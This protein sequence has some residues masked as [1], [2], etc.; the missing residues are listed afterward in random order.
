MMRFAAGLLALLTVVAGVCLADEN[1]PLLL[2][3]PTISATQIVFVYAGDLWSVPRAGGV[4]TRLT[5]GV[6]TASLPVFSPDGSEIAF[7]GEYDGNADVYVIPAGGGT[8][9]RLTYHPAPDDVIGW[10]RDGKSVL[11]ASQRNSYSFFNR[12]YTVSR[13][14]GFPTELPLPG[15]SEGSYSP[16]GKEIAY[17]PLDHAFEIWKRYRGGRSSKVWI[18]KLA[19]SSVTAIPRENTNDFNPM[20]VDERVFF[21]SDRAGAMSLFS[22]DTKTKSVAVALKND[23]LDFKYASAGPGAIAIEQFGAIWLYDLKSGAAHKVDIRISG[24]LPQLRTRYENVG[25]RIR[26]A[27]ISPTGLRAV[28]EARGEILTV[29]AEKGDIRNLTNTPGADERY[30]AWSPDGKSIAYFSD[31]SGEEQLYVKNQNGQGDSQKIDLGTPGSF[32]FFPTWSPDSKRIAYTDKR[33]NLWYVDLE[34]K[35][36]VKVFHDRFTGPEQIFK[37]A[38]SPDSKWLAY[39]GQEVSHMRSVWLYSLETGKSERVTDAM[40][41]SVSPV[42][43]KSGKYLYF[44]SSTDAGPTKDTSM[45]S[46]DRPVTSNVY[47]VVLRKDLPSPLAPLS[48]E[49]GEG[50]ADAAKAD[51]AKADGGKEKEKEKPPVVVK[52]DFEKIGQR[53]LAMPIPARNY[54]EL[55]AGKDGVLFLV[56][57]PL[58][59]P[60]NGADTLSAHRFELKTRRTD[61]LVENI[62]AFY[63]SADGEKL[64]Y[65]HAG[66]PQ[67]GGGAAAQAWSIAPLPPAPV[68]GAPG[69]GAASGGGGNPPGAKNLNFA[70]MEVRIEPIVEWKELYHEAFRLE[71]D[72]FYDANFHGLDLAGTEKKF[73]AYLQGVGSRDD[74]NY[75]FKETM[76]DLTVGHLFVRGGE[77]PEVKRIPVG[78]LGAD[79]KVENGRYRFARVYDGENWNPQLHAPLTQPGVN[80]VEGEYL[81]AVNGREVRGSDEVYSF[82]EETAGKSTLLR[83]GPNADGSGSREVSVVPVESEMGL[84]ELAWVEGNRR[85]VEELS[86]GRLAYIYLPDTASGGYT[87]FNRYFFSQAGKDGAVVDE[88]FNGGGT[89]TDYILDYLRRTLMNYR[90]TRDG[91]DMT[92]PVSLIRGPKAM[93]INEYAG[94]GGDA[95][96]WH[97]RQAKVGTLV[98]K[99]TWGG[100]VGFFGPGESLMDG[101]TVT[102]PSRGFWTPNNDWEVENHGIAPDV[103]VEQDPKLVR[104]GRDPQLERTVEL[105]LADLEKNPLPKY[106]KPA[107][108]NYHKSGSNAASAA[109]N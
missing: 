88:R 13:D 4:A 2:H 60:L 69:S 54:T 68:P 31:E 71:R 34:K 63:V 104:A 19:D 107:Y 42:F 23:G 55:I 92:T 8:P 46:Y 93:I 5:A 109:S 18:A 17:V 49:E 7:T 75:I 94:S 76:G 57:G 10:T 21:I 50:K 20:W 27:D 105:L 58:V 45:L 15:G 30:P 77:G 29:P 48:D 87:Y 95:M 11:F 28:F 64:L 47:V 51:G 52:V 26:N 62:L 96:P 14:G 41:D 108:P 74:L 22:Y 99:R 106:K 78:L 56:E 85:K 80:V 67:P 90:T 44:L 40:S 3:H 70:A 103:E 32:F 65:R 82:F 66:P 37:A 86:K 81:L 97:F 79:Y 43:D 36:P 101:G 102:A 83:V 100:L 39:T 24:D 59:A 16:D 98:G 33:L 84:R 25:N 35:T 6:G 9:R 12:L 61:R 73:A 53:I 91:E 89:N 72:F 38:W 1:P